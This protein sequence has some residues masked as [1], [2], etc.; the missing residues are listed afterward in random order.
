MITIAVLDRTYTGVELHHAFA[1][2]E[3]FQLGPTISF[4]VGAADV[5]EHLVDLEDSLQNDF[6]KSE[7]MVHFII[8]IP[9]ISIQETVVWQR[10]FIRL[11]AEKLIKEV[12]GIDIEIEGDDIMI[13]GQKLSVSIATLSQF[14]G[15]IHA[16]INVHVGAGCPVDA[17][18]LADFGALD[19]HSEGDYKWASD[20]AI[21]FANEYKDVVKATYKV[22]GV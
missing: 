8:E 17:I 21:N 4:F 18:G 9:N 12:E 14:S 5:K 6:I 15:L 3:A 22:I 1:Y 10:L 19:S 16:G 11:V 7:R 2:E 20:V 13:E